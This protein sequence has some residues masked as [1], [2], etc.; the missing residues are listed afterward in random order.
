MRIRAVL[1]A[2][3]LAWS[4]SA[5]TGGSEPA[6]P[7]VTATP[8]SDVVTQGE[9]APLPFAATPLWTSE[10][11]GVPP[12][13]TRFALHGDAVVMFSEPKGGEVDRL[14]VVDAATG[15]T[16]WSAGV[17]KPLRGGHGELWH[18][19]VS[20][21][22][23]PQVVDRGGD[24]GVLVVTTR[25]SQLRQKPFGLALLS[26][27]DG[28]VLWRR[29]LIAETRTPP[30]DRY[31]YP[32]QLLT[33]D[34]TA[35]VSLIPSYGA[36]VAE[37]R[38]TVVDARTGKLLW[39]REATQPAVVA[40][41]VV[42]SEWADPASTPFDLAVAG[43]VVVLDAATGRTRWSLRG[44]IDTGRVA[45]VAGGLLLVREKQHAML[46]APILLDLASGTELD[47]MPAATGNCV[48]DRTAMI[49]CEASLSSQPHLLTVRSDERRVRTSGHT[50]PDG[51]LS[52]VANG[53]IYYSGGLNEPAHEVS[54]SGT[55]LTGLLPDGYL[56]ALSNEYAVFRFAETEGYEIYRVG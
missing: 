29:P 19:P 26:G 14:S 48:D 43:T 36:M 12:Y 21:D 33:D 51:Q 10:A 41:S 4:V 50:A 25:R 54:R 5:C 27:K 17:W 56:S 46:A 2:A 37:L 24:W 39:T 23:R 40:G 31:L 9:G 45:A 8:S 1:S 20:F 13:A 18:G 52:L 49:A 3:V 53:R 42:A 38:M 7:R 44:R 47:R 30:H 15:K 34:R 6:E 16:R 32:G 35:A 55:E 22:S 28:H 11:K